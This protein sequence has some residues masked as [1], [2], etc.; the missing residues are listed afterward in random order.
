MQ[1]LLKSITLSVMMIFSS[2]T[3][4]ACSGLSP[5]TFSAEVRVE[6]NSNW[7]SGYSTVAV[8]RLRSNV[9]EEIEVTNVSINKGQCDYKAVNFPVYF[10]MGQTLRLELKCGTQNVVQVDVETTQG[11]LSYQ[12][13]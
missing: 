3:L 5:D 11:T 2:L 8:L 7:W 13:N 10:K 12:F 1:H 4:T 9:T 6:D